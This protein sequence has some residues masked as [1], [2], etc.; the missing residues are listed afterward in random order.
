[1]R[2]SPTD[3]RT[4]MSDKGVGDTCPD[5]GFPGMEPLAGLT[6]GDEDVMTVCQLPIGPVENVATYML[7]CANCGHVKQYLALAVA[8]WK[9]DQKTKDLKGTRH[10]NPRHKRQ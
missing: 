3:F 8:S 2:L 5:C 10:G 9:Q 4:Y 6:R 7:A 1:M